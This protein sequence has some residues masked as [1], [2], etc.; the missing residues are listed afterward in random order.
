MK[1]QYVV[2]KTN[3]TKLNLHAPCNNQ[4][5]SAMWKGNPQE[6]LWFIRDSRVDQ[7]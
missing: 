6:T 3:Q 4:N 5:I 1:S 7:D 2:T